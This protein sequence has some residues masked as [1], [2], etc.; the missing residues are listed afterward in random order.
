MAGSKYLL[1]LTG[2]FVAVLLISG[3]V[4][5][6]I[7][8]IG[9]FIFDGGTLLFPLSYIFGDILTEVYGYRT[10]RK[11]IWTG[12]VAMLLMIAMIVII[13]FLPAN[14][15]RW[16]QSAYETILMATPR[17]FL[18]S[19]IAYFVGEFVNAFVLAKMKV[20][21]E[22]KHLWMRTIGS[23]IIGQAVDTLVFVMIA[24]YGIMDMQTLWIIILSNYMF[25]VLVEVVL[26]PLTYRVV[27]YL[28]RREETDVY[29]VSTNFNPFVLK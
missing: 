27:A 25:K 17:I 4:S 15:E 16:Q 12:L 26:T 10:S 11:V 8:D 14:A 28:K 29:D 20:W 7:I 21:M 24:F 5:T 2:M 6:K 22:G 23:T 18:G 3:I 1:P 19:I 9:P 13:N